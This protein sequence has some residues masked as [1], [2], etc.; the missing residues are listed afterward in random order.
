[1]VRTE[2]KGKGIIDLSNYHHMLV[3]T[4]VVTQLL[5]YTFASWTL[6]RNFPSLPF[7]H[8][9]S[10][11]PSPFSLP[12]SLSFHHFLILLSSFFSVS[13]LPSFFHVRLSFT[14]LSHLPY[15]HIQSS[16]TSPSTPLPLYTYL[17]SLYLARHL[18]PIRLFLTYP[19]P[20][21]TPHVIS[22]IS[23]QPI[24]C[25]PLYPS[26]TSFSPFI[27]PTY[28]YPSFTYVSRYLANLFPPPCL[29][30]PMYVC[31]SLI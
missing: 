31:M 17:L 10:F 2:T 9:P 11:H 6:L 28:P 23:C 20:S 21:L 1:M 19:Y 5:L 24:S 7:P 12:V 25:P 29:S 26:V 18:C 13:Y 30:Q 16:P 22:S 4:V 15:S 27:S 8:F 14:L 3:I